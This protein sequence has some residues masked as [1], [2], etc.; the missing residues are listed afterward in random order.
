MVNVFPDV[1][2][3]Q[4]LIGH[5]YQTSLSS[6]QYWAPGSETPIPPLIFRGFLSPA[7]KLPGH[8]LI[9]FC[10]R[11]HP[12]ISHCLSVLSNTC[13]WSLSWTRRIRPVSSNCFFKIHFNIILPRMSGSSKRSLQV[14]L[15]NF[16]WISYLSSACCAPFLILLSWSL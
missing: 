16:L 10:Y 5:Y 7:A 2:F 1:S 14:F 4:P 15:P 8:N 12:I 6:G 9:I 3:R 13:H 11:S